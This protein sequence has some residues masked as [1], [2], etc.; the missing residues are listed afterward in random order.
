MSVANAR[1]IEC[2]RDS[3][4]K[5]HF[6]FLCSEFSD[7]FF[8]VTMITINGVCSISISRSASVSLPRSLVISLFI[9]VLFCE[10]RVRKCIGIVFN[11]LVCVC[12]CVHC[13]RGKGMAQW[14]HFSWRR[15]L[16]NLRA[17]IPFALFLTTKVATVHSQ[18]SND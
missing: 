4:S 13:N 8:L 5:R 3:N 6:F 2:W 16:T 12:V 9:F 1:I 18:S 15:K 17:D 10:E 11:H 14:C 7:S